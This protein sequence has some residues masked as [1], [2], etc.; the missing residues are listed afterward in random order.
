[1][2]GARL[3]VPQHRRVQGCEEGVS[4]QKIKATLAGAR[5]C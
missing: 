4:S 5:M 3:E 2:Y 1:M